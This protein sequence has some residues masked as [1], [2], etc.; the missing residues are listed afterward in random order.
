MLIYSEGDQPWDVFRRGSDDY[1]LVHCPKPDAVFYLPV[2]D[3]NSTIPINSSVAFRNTHWQQAPNASMV[4]PFSWTTLNNLNMHGGL[5]P[6]PRRL[7]DNKTRIKSGSQLRCYP[8]LI[9]EYKKAHTR[10][11]DSKRAGEIVCCQANNATACALQLNRQ[12]AKYASPLANEGH[13]LPLP[14]VTTNGSNVTL[15]IAYYAKDVKECPRFGF[16]YSRDGV[17][18]DAYVS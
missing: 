12:L 6:C 17:I 16:L 13:V 3:T 8:W 18:S 4:E 11:A 5:E 14:A 7:C 15:W 1:Q 2:Y 9:A 10:E